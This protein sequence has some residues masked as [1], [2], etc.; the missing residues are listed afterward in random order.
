MSP[1][2]WSSPETVGLNRL[3]M[4]NIEQYEKLA[5][6]GTWRFQ[7]LSTP[8]ENP[9]KRWAKIEVPSLWSDGE[10]A[11][12]FA[13]S[14]IS[15]EGG[16]PFGLVAPEVPTL[17]PTGIYETNF[18]IPGSWYNKRIILHLGGVES[19]ARIYINNDLVGISKDSRLASEFL[20]NSFLRA[21]KN[22][23]RIHVSRWAD[24]SHL[25]DIDHQWH[26]GISRSVKLIA[27]SEV[28]IEKFKAVAELAS[29]KST[30]LLSVEAHIGAVNEKSYLGYTLR[31]YIE[32]LH[33]VKS[34]RSSI[35]LDGNGDAP[36]NRITFE[37][38][39]PRVEAW[40]AENP[41]LYT[42]QIEL[43]D[44]TGTIVQISSQK[45][46]FRSVAIKGS[47][48]YINGKRVL[49]SGSAS[50]PEDRNVQRTATRD[51]IRQVLLELKRRHF[52]VLTTADFPSEPAL[53]DLCDELGFYLIDEANIYPTSNLEV[54][55]NPQYLGAILDRASR[56]IA[57]DIHHPSVVAWSINKPS[58]YAINFETAAQY[59]E[60]ADT[61]RNLI[62]ADNGVVLDFD[63][64]QPA[65][66]ISSTNLTSGNLAITNSQSFTDTSDFDLHWKIS[67]D[68]EVLDNGKLKNPNLLPGKTGKIAIKSKHLNSAVK[69]QRVL[70]V[71]IV[72]KKSTAWSS[73]QSEYA[74]FEFPLTKKRARR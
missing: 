61:S 71:S 44:P 50:T 29:D 56:M 27:T 34:A 22:V 24:S 58:E 53:L 68:G 72:R 63:E 37:A 1:R 65:I 43:V 18:E 4:L 48:L 54:G 14:V 51:Q 40:S 39:I 9:R 64:V 66:Y 7:L 74:R 30:G 19:V 11:E 28:F 6:D 57:R 45:V 20:I 67:L 33:K 8:D 38:R 35:T 25:E 21:G 55:E 36:L 52:T 13:D 17:N 3:P 10:N 62:D 46:G 69:G 2:Y 32:E 12:L 26:G 23:I 49:L 31:T 73:A 59:V 70:E 41:H 47:E 42:L 60:L 15:S 5:L 16:S